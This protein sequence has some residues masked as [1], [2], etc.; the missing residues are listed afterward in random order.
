M[1]RVCYL[2]ASETRTLR[3]STGDFHVFALLVLVLFSLAM[4]FDVPECG[5]QTS[6]EQMETMEV[7]VTSGMT[8][9]C[10]VW[11][12]DTVCVEL[13]GSAWH[14]R[15]N[16]VL[17]ST[18]D[19]PLVANRNNHTCSLIIL[20]LQQFFKHGKKCL[21]H[22][23]CTEHFVTVYCTDN[24]MGQ[25]HG[26]PHCGTLV[27]A[28]HQDPTRRFRSPLTATDCHQSRIQLISIVLALTLGSL[29]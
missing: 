18:S 9:C 17:F 27:S 7:A 13:V 2:F 23:P 14:W 16:H 4:V 10:S 1:F 25:F 22:H 26:G 19:V 28:T 21:H 8:R 20:F 6:R 3:Y 11:C 5:R 24:G 12:R 29:L 15:N